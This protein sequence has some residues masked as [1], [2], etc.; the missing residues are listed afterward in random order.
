MALKTARCTDND[1][2]VE[3]YKRLKLDFLVRKTMATNLIR[4][5][6]M[7]A[8][9]VEALIGATYY[10]ARDHFLSLRKANGVLRWLLRKVE[11]YPKVDTIPFTALP[12]DDLE[13]HLTERKKYKPASDKFRAN[14]KMLK[15]DPNKMPDFPT[16]DQLD[17]SRMDLV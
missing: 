10:D 5:H 3:V 6:H 17:L 7:W 13:K 1:S 2:F 8:T 4:R 12:D 16:F 15:S 9:V 14:F 11:V